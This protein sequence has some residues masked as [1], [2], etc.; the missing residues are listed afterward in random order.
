MQLSL[1]NQPIF[2]SANG[3]TSI[4]E[5][6]F[7]WITSRRTL[8]KKKYIKKLSFS[9][10]LGINTLL[11]IFFL[12]FVFSSQQS[13]KINQKHHGF[14]EHPRES[15]SLT[16]SRSLKISIWK[17]KLRENLMVNNLYSKLFCIKE[18]HI[19]LFGMFDDWSWCR[20]IAEAKWSNCRGLVGEHNRF[21]EVLSWSQ[22]QS[23]RCGIQKPKRQQQ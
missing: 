15:F 11:N 18:I 9:V 2:L 19:V 12:F 20:R 4:D 7:R 5:A 16:M 6:T 17:L 3:G 23:K 10:S 22:R 21:T 14:V 1:E 8:S 13:L